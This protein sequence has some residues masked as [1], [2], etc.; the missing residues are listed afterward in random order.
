M[1][2]SN[3]L[4]IAEDQLNA[5]IDRLTNEEKTALKAIVRRSRTNEALP[6]NLRLDTKVLQ[7][8]IEIGLIKQPG[9]RVKA[10]P[11]GESVANR[12]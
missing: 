2:M 7:F 5:I 3:Q 4:P 8:L 6:K 11:I 9:M 12:L 10:T 1:L